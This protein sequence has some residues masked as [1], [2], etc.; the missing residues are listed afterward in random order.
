MSF[1][2]GRTVSVGEVKIVFEKAYGTHSNGLGRV[3]PDGS[4][5]L[6]QQVFD[7]GKPPHQRSWHIRQTGSGRYAGTMSEAIG[8]VTIDKVGDRYRF[9]FAMDGHLNVEQVMTPLPGGRVASSSAKIR[10]YGFVVATTDGFVR[11]LA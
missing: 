5:L 3:E 8:P 9:R 2:V 7:D 10:K 1:F 11:K 6:L 4:L